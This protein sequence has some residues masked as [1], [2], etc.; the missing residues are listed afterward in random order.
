MCT[1]LCV[2]VSCCVR[3]DEVCCPCHPQSVE[4]KHLI[5]ELP[6]VCLPK[7]SFV[8]LI[9]RSHCTHTHAHRI[10]LPCGCMCTPTST[11]LYTVLLVDFVKYKMEGEEKYTAALLG[12]GVIDEERFVLW[13]L[14]SVNMLTH[15]LIN[16]G[17]LESL[18]MLN[19][20]FLRLFLHP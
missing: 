2:C 1:R 12:D 9:R 8:C 6:L 20:H 18:L 13:P 4:L 15:A 17:A 7:Y 14:S 19:L 11:S 3:P 10:G 16:K 5:A